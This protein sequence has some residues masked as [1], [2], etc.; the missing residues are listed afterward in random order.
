MAKI[1]V[2]K[3]EDILW[4]FPNKE[5]EV[6][7]KI[8]IENIKFIES[9]AF[10]LLSGHWIKC[11]ATRDGNWNIFSSTKCFPMQE[12]QKVILVKKNCKIKI[13]MDEINN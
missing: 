2:Y 1:R 10:V 13:M 6:L 5:I 4:T 8:N 3:E 7:T 12:N 11:E 9:S